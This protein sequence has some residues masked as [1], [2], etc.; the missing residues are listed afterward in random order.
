LH[1]SMRVV[2]GLYTNQDN[3]EKTH[4]A[5]GINIVS[6][7]AAGLTTELEAQGISCIIWNPDAC[8][9]TGE[10]EVQ[11]G[12]ETAQDEMAARRILGLVTA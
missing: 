4:M 7:N 6:S 10:V 2:A 8:T 1:R 5:F 3:L 12:F 9:A 11:L